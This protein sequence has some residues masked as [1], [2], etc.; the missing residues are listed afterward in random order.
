MGIFRRNVMMYCP[1]CK[2]IVETWT[3]SYMDGNVKVTN[4]L[5]VSCNAILKVVREEVMRR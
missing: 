3:D 4:T 5:C 1:R 2:K